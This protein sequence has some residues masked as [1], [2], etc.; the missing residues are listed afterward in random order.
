MREA[1]KIVSPRTGRALTHIYAN[2][3]LSNVVCLKAY[4]YT[5]IILCCRTMCNGQEV[6]KYWW[7][8]EMRAKPQNLV[9]TSFNFNKWLLINFYINYWVHNGTSSLTQVQPGIIVD[10]IWRFRWSIILIV[11]QNK[12]LSV[13]STFDALLQLVREGNIWSKIALQFD[14]VLVFPIIQVVY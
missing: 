11:V 1:T 14:G 7:K 10:D 4:L 2:S 6:S 8:M 12:L 9:S 3:T 13:V 5:G